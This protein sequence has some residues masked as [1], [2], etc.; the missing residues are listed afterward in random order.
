M[1]GGYTATNRPEKT[2]RIYMNIWGNKFR[3][4][5]V[6][7]KHILKQISNNHRINTSRICVIFEL[8]YLSRKLRQSC[9]R[10]T[11]SFELE[12]PYKLLFIPVSWQ[13]VYL[14]VILLLSVSCQILLEDVAPFEC[15]GWFGWFSVDKTYIAQASGIGATIQS[16][17]RVFRIWHRSH[18]IYIY[19]Y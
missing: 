14:F 6:T 9:Q 2:Y 18:G 11:P 1:L 7:V 17:L 13:L 8:W 3:D 15:E 4:S 10:I 19:I 12:K 5:K 16:E